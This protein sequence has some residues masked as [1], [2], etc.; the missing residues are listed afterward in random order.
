[1]KCIS[2]LFFLISTTILASNGQERPQYM[3]DRINL[4]FENLKEET[5]S[6]WGVYNGQKS[7]DLMEFNDHALVFKLILDL[8][9]GQKEFNVLDIGAGNFQFADALANKNIIVNIYSLI[10][11]FN[12]E[13]LEASSRSSRDIC[14]KP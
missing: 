10:G 9:L 13:N 5:K 8:P 11:A 6:E 14:S 2:I 7:Y 12:I 3:K 4:V 1:M